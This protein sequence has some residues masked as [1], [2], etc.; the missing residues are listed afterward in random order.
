MKKKI[1]SCLLA[2]SLIISAFAGLDLT[3]FVAKAAEVYESGDYEYTVNFR[4]E[5]I[6]K[7]YMGNDREVTIPSEINGMPVTQIGDYSFNGQSRLIAP[8]EGFENH[9]N[10]WYNR[11]IRKVVIPSTVKTIGEYAF[12]DMDRLKEVVFSEGLK[13]IEQF[14]FAYCP[15]LEEISL[16]ESL[17]DFTLLAFEQT[18]I[19]EIVLG[20]NVRNLNLVDVRGSQVKRIICNAETTI[21]EEILLDNE[22]VL[23]EIICNG[24]LSYT[25]SR[26]KADTL[27]RVVCE[28]DASYDTVL[29]MM[30]SG[31]KFCCDINGDNIVFSAES[32]NAPQTFE[33][34]GFRYYLNDRSEAVISR[35]IGGESVVI[36]PSSLGS[37][38]VTAI[39]PLAFSSMKTAAFSTLLADDR[40]IEK[41]LLVSISLP[42]TVKNIGKF[43]FAYNLALEE[44]IIPF[45][46]E[47]IHAECFFG[48]E[49]LKEI[50]L[51]ES[52][53]EIGNMAFRWCDAL[54][55]IDMNGVSKV[56][57][58]AFD[59]C[60]KLRNIGYSEK[61]R[62]IGTA[63][64]SRCK[65]TETLDLTYVTKIGADA[66]GSTQVKKVILNDSLEKLEGGTFQGCDKL[67]EI[68]FPSKLISI[69]DCCFRGSGINKAVFNEGLKEI[70][71]LAFDG[72]KELY[73]LELPESLEKIGNFAFE[74]TLVEIVVI[75][76]N[77]KI[78]GYRAFG[79]CKEL[80]ILYFNA[81]NC[82]VDFYDN[83]DEK[84]DYD[85]LGNA[86][87]FIG[88]KLKEIHLGEGI[89][90]IGGNVAPYGTFENCSELESIMIPDTVSEIGTAAFKNCSSLVT[91]VISDS[92]TRIAEDAFEG[93]HNLTILCFKNSYV[94]TYAQAQGI[95]VSTFVVAP[96]PNQTY[97]GKEI[98]PEV[99][100]S[101]SGDTLHKNIDFGVTYANNVNA[102]EAD[103]TVKGKGD[104]KNFSNKVKF[105][106]VTKSI[107]SATIAPVADQAYTGSAI[108]PELIVTDGTKLLVK[109]KDYTVSYS[110][111]RRE[112]TATVKI[113]GIGNYSGS[114]TTEFRIVNMG[115][116][117]S[118]FSRLFSEISFFFAKIIAF[119][120][121][122][123]SFI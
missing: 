14:A 91:A 81:K 83:S 30:A 50:I 37:H 88:C 25:S 51:P 18:A 111:N 86:S 100:V 119:F 53:N 21:I 60:R 45:G 110:D 48:C 2:L 36:V 108:T 44:I 49:S 29:F 7:S 23:E 115:G 79:Y 59:D 117:E 67:E 87:P 69:G 38:K 17:A 31:Y 20:S 70:G 5:V 41:D 46:V 93:C 40:Y 71:A 68:N 120:T 6:I 27:K 42:D 84:L 101:F 63:A 77:L 118:I 43:A 54:E 56:G 102:G 58:R 89:T 121:D 28:G 103:V 9:P 61:L 96:I 65:L 74:N 66:F 47:K 97:T 10:A 3:G 55:S 8:G 123:F 85:N 80:E 104:Y 73:I 19:E 15:K 64:F 92:V 39:A 13:T 95:R 4:N 113:S 90:A 106:I 105:T 99:S 114:L 32:G 26:I 16:P 98:K 82:K 22:S 24:N 12:A 76:E 116:T 94:Y 34:E 62:E 78:I 1:I 122:I 72:C 35:Y 33:A 75:H 107:S 57:N 112:G 109:D 11:R 52:V